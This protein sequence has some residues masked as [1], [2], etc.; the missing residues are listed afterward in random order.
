MEKRIKS[1]SE[2]KRRYLSLFV[3]LAFAEG[4]KTVSGK[5]RQAAAG[6]VA[7]YCL[8]AKS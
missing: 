8:T 5:K 4:F 7:A 2:N 3:P 1:V 6:V